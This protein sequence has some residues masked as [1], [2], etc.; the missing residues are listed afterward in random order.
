[1]IAK[2]GIFAPIIS[3]TPVITTKKLLGSANYLTWSSSV[4]LWLMSQGHDDHL[5]RKRKMYLLQI[6]Y[7]EKTNA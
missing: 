3:E 5:L 7:A 6:Q 2:H 4:E 1:M